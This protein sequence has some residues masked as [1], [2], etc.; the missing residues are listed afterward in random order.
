MKHRVAADIGGT[1]TDIAYLAADGTLATRKVLS[2]PPNYGDAVVAGLLELAAGLGIRLDAFAE[3]LHGCTIAANT[4]LEHKGAK[5]ALLTTEGFRDVLEL[6]RIRTPQLYAPLYRKPPPLVPRRLRLEVGERIDAAGGVVRPITNDDVHRAIARMKSEGVEAVAVCLLH[7]YINPTHEQAIGAILRDALPD[8]FVSLS[9]DVLP[10]MREYER[11]STT[12]VNAYIGP[13]VR[14]YLNAMIDQL[15]AAGAEGRLMIMLS[16][17]GILDARNVIDEPA[18]IVE[19]GP[20]AG[21]V[22]AA[23]LAAENDYGNVI[24]FDMGGTTAKASIVEEGKLIIADEYEVGGG[25]SSTSKLVGGGGYAVGMPVIDISEIGA[26]GGSIVWHDKAGSIKVGPQSAGAVPGP[27]CYPGG[28]SEPTVTDANVVLGYLNPEALAGGTVAIDAA[29]AHA[30]IETRLAAELGMAPLETAYGVHTV[31]NAN[32]IRAI[33]G[34]TTY[35]GRNPRDFALLAFGGSGGVH[36]VALARELQTRRVIV[37]RAAG[38]FSAVGLLLA[39]LELN[40]SRAFPCL[41]SALDQRNADRVYQEVEAEIAARLDRDRSDITFR[42]LADMRYAGQASELTV[43]LPDGALD[44]AALAELGRGFEREHEIRYGH[45]FRGEYPLEIVNLR[46]IGTVVPDGPRSVRRQ[47]AREEAPR[48]TRE[49]YFGPQF[50]LVEARVTSRAGLT[51]APQPGPV[52]VEEYEGTVV[53]PPDCEIYLDGADSIIIDLPPH[54]GGAT[55][56]G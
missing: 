7:S 35:R 31:A 53:V 33:K 49:A 15:A 10:Q 28:G 14:S 40:L 1:F 27:A 45:S 22:G 30:V 39:D 24:T 8:C 54:P 42:R 55:E 46:V 48:A 9:I 51:D 12:V 6:R 23:H 4:I 13:P 38:V 5:T 43:V 20:A 21:V 52:I 44:D 47:P 18:Q 16:S 36:A 50:G 2:T 11:T 25:M 3:V 32:M 17:G 41:V 26:G 37:P 34:V 19:C 29:R 56:R